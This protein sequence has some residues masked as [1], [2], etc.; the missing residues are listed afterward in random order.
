MLHLNLPVAVLAGSGAATSIEDV[1]NSGLP[2]S[3]RLLYSLRMTAVG[4]L[5]IFAV[6]GIIYLVMLVFR[7]V[8]YHPPAKVNEPAPAAPAPVPAPVPVPAPKPV[9]APAAPGSACAG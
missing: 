2:M 9:P 8:F 1:M 6:L 5:T 4:L 7:A 3:E